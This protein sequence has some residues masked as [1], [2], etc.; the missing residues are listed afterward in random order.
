MPGG[1]CIKIKHAL[2]QSLEYDILELRVRALCWAPLLQ[3]PF[4]PYPKGP[5]ICN[6]ARTF[7]F[8]LDKPP[9]ALHRSFRY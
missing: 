3:N 5:V 6:E 9:S 1:N 2:F 4:T 8:D 7:I